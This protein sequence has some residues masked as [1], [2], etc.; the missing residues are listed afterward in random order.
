VALVITSTDSPNIYTVGGL[1]F[2]G[3]RCVVKAILNARNMFV[4]PRTGRFDSA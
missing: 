2:Y 3:L 1:S 4:Q